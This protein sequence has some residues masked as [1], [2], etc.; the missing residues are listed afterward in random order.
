[1]TTSLEILAEKC[2]LLGEENETLR[3][4]I[5]WLEKALYGDHVNIPICGLTM[6]E[7]RVLGC[8]ST[9]PEGASKIKIYAALY[10]DR[11]DEPPE[12]KI[13]DVLV[14]KIRKKLAAQEIDI[15][16]VWGWGYRLPPLSRERLQQIREALS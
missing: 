10:A 12:P 15:E 4:R 5:R 6:A 3:E 1:M 16:T 7:A 13:V 11:I 14:C 8:I 9:S 2:D